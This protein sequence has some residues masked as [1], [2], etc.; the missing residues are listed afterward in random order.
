MHL[1]QSSKNDT[2]PQSVFF[3]LSNIIQ[4]QFLFSFYFQL[5]FILVS[6]IFYSL[7]LVFISFL[8]FSQFF[9]SVLVFRTTL[10]YFSTFRNTLCMCPVASLKIQMQKSHG[11]T[12]LYVYCS[13]SLN[14]GIHSFI[15]SFIHMFA[16]LA[17]V[18]VHLRY[19]ATRTG[20]NV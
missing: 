17:L 5:V 18:Q 15:H 13:M 19:K 9:I 20:G 8:F 12:E 10:F 7:V 14:C 16:G 4:F 3:Q 11:I 2:D 6:V 1:S